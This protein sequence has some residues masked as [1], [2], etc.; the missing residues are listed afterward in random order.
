MSIL[1]EYINALLRRDFVSFIGKCA[2]TLSPGEVYLENWHIFAIAHVLQGI[3]DGKIKRLIING[4]PRSLKSK[5]ASVAFPAYAL[6]HDP[7]KRFVCVSYANDLSIKHAGDFRAIID[8]DW[9]GDAF[10]LMR[11]GATKNNEV[12]FTTREFGGRFATSVGGTLTGR[13]GD[14]IIIDDPLKAG[15]AQSARNRDSANQWLVNTAMSRLNDKM[16]GAIIIVMQRVHEDDLTGFVTRASDDWTILTLPAIA[17][18]DQSIQIGPCRF[19]ERKIGDVLHPEREPLEVLLGL[20][21]QMGSGLFAAQYQQQPVPPEG[22]MIKRAWVRRYAYAPERERG[23][24]LIISWD[25]ASK[26]R[27]DND[28]SVATVWLVREGSYYLL[29]VVRRRVDYPGLR[30]L[31]INLATQYKPTRVLVEDV[32]VGTPLIAELKAKG[33]PAIAVAPENSKEAR[34]SAQSGKLESGLV[35]LPAKAEWL[36]DLEAELFAFPGGKHDDQVDSISQA[37]AHRGSTMR[38]VLYDID[39]RKRII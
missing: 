18:E 23:E 28:W 21:R 11:A 17:E 38:I 16:T 12:E 30:A 10:P 9:Y 4:P 15:D 37:L 32:G 19:H 27:P 3:I 33:I 6:G 31:A 34:M 5:A 13:G 26:T 2:T 22:A 39:T 8:S 29:E 36:P 1:Q 25:T 20:K 7:T 35:F 14:I 24:Q